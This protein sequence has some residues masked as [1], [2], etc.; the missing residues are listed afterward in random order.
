MT[1]SPSPDTDIRVLESVGDKTMKKI[2]AHGFTSVEKVV[3]TPEAVTDVPGVGA[4]TAEKLIAEARDYLNA[5]GIE[6][7]VL[8]MSVADSA[9]GVAEVEPGPD[10]NGLDEAPGVSTDGQS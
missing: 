2:I 3:E 4:K 7:Q 9:G 10:V 1:P 6:K 8:A 5:G